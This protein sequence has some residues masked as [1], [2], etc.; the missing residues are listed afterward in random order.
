LITGKR[1]EDIVK[2]PINLGVPA[3]ALLLG[4]AVLA[5]SC[6]SW[7]ARHGKTQVPGGTLVALESLGEGR[8]RVKR[9]RPKLIVDLTHEVRLPTGFLKDAPPRR[10]TWTGSA[11]KR[12]GKEATAEAGA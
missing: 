11:P 9:T 4:V 10:G 7:K 3:I 2:N 5:S 12:V 8:I 6:T 1:F